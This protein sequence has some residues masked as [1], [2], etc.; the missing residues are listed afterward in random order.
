MPLIYCRIWVS[1]HANFSH[2]LDLAN[3]ILVVY[4]HSM[5]FFHPSIYPKLVTSLS[6]LIILMCFSRIINSGFSSYVIHQIKKQHN[7]CCL[8]L[9]DVKAD[10]WIQLLGAHFIYYQISHNLPLDDFSGDYCLD[11]LFHSSCKMKIFLILTF[12][13]HLFSMIIYKVFFL[14]NYLVILYTLPTRKAR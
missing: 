5:Y 8:N 12:L 13:L 11:T 4:Q 10:H 3:Y 9:I 2:I 14:I 6:D 1:F 7:V